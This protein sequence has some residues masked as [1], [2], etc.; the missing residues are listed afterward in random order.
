M[1]VREGRRERRAESVVGGEGEGVVERV[2]SWDWRVEGR[3][4]GAVGAGKKG[5]VSG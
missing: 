4:E 2:E 3:V 1:E 5:G